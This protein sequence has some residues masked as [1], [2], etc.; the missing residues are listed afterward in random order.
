MNES[1][2]KY[3]A[4]KAVVSLLVDQ[5]FYKELKEYVAQNKISI[6]QLVEISLT[7]YMDKH[8]D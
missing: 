3:T 4:D 7:E 1:F 8:K 2:K 5:E 6:K